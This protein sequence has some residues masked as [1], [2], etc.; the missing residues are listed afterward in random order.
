M[1][2]LMPPVEPLRDERVISGLELQFMMAEMPTATRNY[3]HQRQLAGDVFT[4]NGWRAAYRMAR[5]FTPPLPMP[6]FRSAFHGGG[7]E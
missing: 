4:T 1:H 5:P 2:H 3:F 6:D 7:C